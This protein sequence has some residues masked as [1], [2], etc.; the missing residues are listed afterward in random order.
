M[1]AMFERVMAAAWTARQDAQRKNEP[2]PNAIYLGRNQWFGLLADTESMRIY[3]RQ[4]D[5]ISTFAGLRMFQVVDRDHLA[6]CYSPS[7]PTHS[8][9]GE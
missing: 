8:A 6:V 9:G 4:L 1:G 7:L 2:E 5:E 3:R